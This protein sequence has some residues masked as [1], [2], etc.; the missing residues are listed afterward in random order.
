MCKYFCLFFKNYPYK[1]NFYI[2]NLSM[3]A[4]SYFWNNDLLFIVS[5]IFCFFPWLALNSSRWNKTEARIW[6]AIHTVTVLNHSVHKGR[7][8]YIN[9]S[10]HWALDPI[11]SKLVCYTK[12]HD[13]KIV[14]DHCNNYEQIKNKYFLKMKLQNLLIWCYF[15]RWVCTKTLLWWNKLMHR[16]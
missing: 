7:T 8:D 12:L 9:S 10:L 1:E 11:H 3:H 2:K 15:W 4:I 16:Q 6:Q 13:Y 14:T 5:C